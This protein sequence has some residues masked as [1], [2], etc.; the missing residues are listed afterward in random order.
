M[1]LA[2]TYR[3]AGAWGAGKG[4]RL[5]AAEVDTNFYD[6][7]LAVNSLQENPAAPKEFTSITLT[8]N[9]LS[10]VLSDA[11]HFEVALPSPVLN[12]TG[13]WQASHDY[14]PSDL[15]TVTDEDAGIESLYYVNRAFTSGLAFAANY[16]AGVGGTLP[17]A[18]LLIEAKNGA[19]GA[20]GAPG[21]GGG[22]G[23][24]TADGDPLLVRTFVSGKPGNG[25]TE[26][27]SIWGYIADTTFYVPTDMTAAL[28]I[29]DFGVSAPYSFIVAKNGDAIGTLDFSGGGTGSLTITAATQFNRGDCFQ[30]QTPA[31]ISTEAV[32]LYLVLPFIYGPAPGG[33]GGGSG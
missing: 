17:Y 1:T 11:S 20:D 9:V 23:T 19:D 33:G 2:L 21:T 32:G 3:T 15:F 13:A 12:P 25:L 24:G 30:I 4:A 28:A 18:S 31:T 8:G 16:G 5:N 22:G 7:Q 10:F 26:G 14:S 6:L 27:Q 29:L